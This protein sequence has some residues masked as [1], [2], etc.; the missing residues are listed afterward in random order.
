MPLRSVGLPPSDSECG[1]IERDLSGT[2][3]IATYI[4]FFSAHSFSL[5][6]RRPSSPSLFLTLFLS[7]PFSYLVMFN[8]VKLAVLLLAAISVAA[9]PSHLARQAHHH[10]EIAARVPQPDVAPVAEMDARDVPVPVKRRLRKRARGRCSPTNPTSSLPSSTPAAPEPSPSL[11]GDERKDPEPSTSTPAQDPPQ[12]TP[13]PDQPQTTPNQPTPDPATT[14]TPTPTPVD[15]PTSSPSPSPT[16]GGDNNNNNNS[17]GGTVY[18]G[19][20]MSMVLFSIHRT[21]T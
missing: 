16:S 19:Q 15:T 3:Y 11:L 4:S 18:S 7:L 5:N 8:A 9:M 12:T 20:G 2:G 6:Q 13:T 21:L 10:R 17:G 14:P 1:V